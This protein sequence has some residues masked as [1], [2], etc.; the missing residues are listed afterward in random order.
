MPLKK[1]EKKED[2]KS[3]ADDI[4][5][6]SKKPI[7]QKESIRFN[8][9]ISTGSTLLDLAISGARIRG[10]GL[11]GGILAEIFGGSGAGKS[12]LL[13]SICASAQRHEGDVDIQDPES[14]LDKEYIEIYGVSIEQEGFSYSRPDTVLQAFQHLHKWVKKLNE[15]RINIAAVDAV[16]ALS[17]ELELDN[18]E[19]D[20]MGMKQAKEFSQNLRKAARLLGQPNLI[21]IFNN[22]VRQGSNGETTPC[23]KGLEFYGSLRIRVS[24]K[25]DIKETAKLKSGKEIEKIIG[26]QSECYIKKSTIDSPYRSCPLSI[27]FNYGLDDIRDQ[28]QWYKDMQ[29]ATT[30]ECPDGKTYQ[31]MARA[32]EYVEE[33]GLQVKLRERTIDLWQ[34]IEDRFK[35]ERKPRV[36]F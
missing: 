31:S 10:G 32:I 22:Q 27:I 2:L 24:K 26:I 30:Y 11:P 29:K 3:L 5:E 34:E 12:S 1:R 33:K 18:E 36:F 28:L 15:D 17:T 6:E 4:A 21:T 8:K 16:A 25:S 35:Q 13:A 20:R 19:G 9:V 14:R 23:G 7:A